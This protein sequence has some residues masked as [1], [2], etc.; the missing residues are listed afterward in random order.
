MFH[1][2]LLRLLSI[3]Q[4]R[5][6]CEVVK[7]L[8]LILLAPATNAEIERIFSALKRVKTYLRSTMGEKR[9]GGLMVLHVHKEDTDL[10]NIIDAANNFTKKNLL[11]H[12]N[13]HNT[14]QTKAVKHAV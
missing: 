2:H 10:I 9:L 6:I 7:L 3:A 13:F 14:T 1:S 5:I 11:G 8:K 4:R 12:S